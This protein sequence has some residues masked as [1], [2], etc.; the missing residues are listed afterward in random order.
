MKLHIN[1]TQYI[2]TNNGIDVSIPIRQGGDNVNAWYCD[3]VEIK[4]V[5]TENFIGDTTKGGPVNFKGITINPHGNGTHTECVGHISTEPYTINHCLTEFHFFG[6]I[7][8]VTPKE[9][10]NKTDQQTD[11]V[12]DAESLREKTKNWN[13]QKAVLIRTLPN[14]A[15]KKTK[16]YSGTN[17]AYFTKDAMELMNQLGVDHFMTDLPSVDREVDGGELAAHHTFWNYPA[18][19][20]THKT[21]SELIY[22]P[23]TLEDGDYLIQIQIM[24]VE[25]DASP[26][27]IMV[28]E[29]INT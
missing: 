9:R 23:N 11:T 4:P 17:P 12:I 5:I 19:P 25:S 28:H 15:D 27:K 16:K 1:A 2:D 10:I 26:S 3:P 20:Q 21:I 14:A 24:S 29:I 6:R 22:I 18:D 7:I 13:N 8:S